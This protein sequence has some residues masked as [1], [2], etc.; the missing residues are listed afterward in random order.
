MLVLPT[1]EVR[2]EAMTL[3]SLVYN[4]EE[5]S[6]GLLSL[7]QATSRA[8]EGEHPLNLK[9]K[10]AGRE[11]D[12][13][14]ITEFYFMGLDTC[15]ARS[16]GVLFEMS[17]HDRIEY[18]LNYVGELIEAESAGCYLEN[19]LMIKKHLPNLLAEDKTWLRWLYD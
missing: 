3:A 13:Q 9:V 4:N 10:V 19:Y 14:F 2:L 12:A 5:N 1:I 7:E 6:H 16:K 8:S 17:A 15:A 18:L 11:C